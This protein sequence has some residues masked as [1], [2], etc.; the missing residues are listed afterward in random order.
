[1]FPVEIVTEYRAH[2][3]T[4]KLRPAIGRVLA[5][6]LI[7]SA[8]TALIT[9]FASSASGSSCAMACCMG[10]PAHAAGS[11]GDHGAAEKSPEPG[12]DPDDPLCRPAQA[13][14]P[15]APPTPTETVT[16]VAEP[17]GSGCG[18]GDGHGETDSETAVDPLPRFSGRSLK[19]PCG[20]ECGACSVN[21]RQMRSGRETALPTA[22]LPRTP[23][24]A[25]RR[26]TPV[27]SSLA[28]RQALRRR[29]VPRGPPT[30][31]PA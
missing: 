9:P 8:L 31:S 14:K 5:L 25:R 1:V 19:E 13:L 16:I 15:A 7:L 26:V 30:A 24:V 3:F 10:M 29:T 4:S 27:S 11:C 6:A 2:K 28:I 23:S 18:T 22:Q 21:G 12:R 17:D 20:Q